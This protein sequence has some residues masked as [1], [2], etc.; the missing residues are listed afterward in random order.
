ML[1]TPVETAADAQAAFEGRTFF[2]EDKL[3]GIRARSTKLAAGS[4]STR[5]RWTRPTS[6][7][8]TSWSK[9]AGFPVNSFWTARSSHTATGRCCRSRT[10]RSGWAGRCLTPKILRDHPARFVAFDVLH[11]NGELLMDRPLRE[12]RAALQSLCDAC[13]QIHDSHAVGKDGGAAVGVR[14]SE[15][16]TTQLIEVSTSEQIAGEFELAQ[17]RRN[18]GSC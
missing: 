16:L 1:A 3:D 4:R 12:R 2:C 11:L 15:L 18:R 6:R 7:S 17:A 10:S 9:S 5:G 8:R 13:P 14:T